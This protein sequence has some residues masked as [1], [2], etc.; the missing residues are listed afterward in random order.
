MSET[1]PLTPDQIHL[2]DQWS[3]WA[4][5]IAT[6]ESEFADLFRS[7]SAILGRLISQEFGSFSL[8]EKVLVI[9]VLTEVTSFG[10]VILD[11]TNLSTEGAMNLILNAL[12]YAVMS[13]DS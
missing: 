8:R 5:A 3:A 10:N 12:M 6:E 9:R 13:S 1:Q 2:L 7:E 11:K 4:S